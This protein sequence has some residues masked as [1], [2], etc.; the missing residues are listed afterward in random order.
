M[1][2]IF[3]IGEA[4]GANEERINAGFVGA[5]GIAL[6]QMLNDAGVIELTDS[7]AT[8]L[9]RYYNE[10]N[11][12]HIDM[13]WRLH[14]ELYRTNV[15]QIHP[16]G[17]KLEHFCGPKPQAIPGFPK[18]GQAGWVG[19]EFSTQLDRLADELEAI[20]P[21][22]V[23]CLGNAALWAMCGK[24]S[25]ISKLRGTTMY[26]THTV[27][28]YKCLLTYH[29]SAVQRQWELRPATVMDLAKIPRENEYPEIRRPKRQVWI[30]PS[31]ED[32]ERFYHDHIRGCGVLSTDIE[33]AGGY[34]TEIGF[35]PSAELAIVI[36]FRDKRSATGNYW[37]DPITE[38]KVWCI[39]QRILGDRTIPKAFQ[40]GLY[41]IAFLLRAYGIPTFG[42][43]HDTML[44]HHALQPE[45]LKGLGF[46][47]SLYT[48]E[49]PWKTERGGTE[50]IKRD[51]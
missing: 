39:V 7:D 49:G 16:P 47:G 26:S 27:A 43:A 37:P 25:G 34:I 4:K 18:L 32:I 30:E 29:P 23:V 40:N 22:L 21:N 38:R 51:E 1:K 28:G 8:Y 14:P 31:L 46:L 3:L 44:L 10:G 50:T 17:N 11:P 13:I 20:D 19:D 2:P 6:L 45:S 5:A 24:G 15:F 9:R 42:A 12:E 35:A 33:T 41:D 48:D 36:P